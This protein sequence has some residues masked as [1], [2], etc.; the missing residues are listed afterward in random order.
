[1]QSDY[2]F[3]ISLFG[4]GGVGKTSLAH[5]YLHGAFDIDTKMTMGASI[6]V[7]YV[8]VGDKRV[9]LQIWDFGGEENFRFLLPVYAQ[10]SSAGILMYDISRYDTFKGIEEWLTFFKEGLS[11]DE[12]NIPLFLV[13]GK[14]DLE[15][16]RSVSKED[17]KKKAE[18]LKVNYFVET[19][20]KTGKNI[21]ELFKAVT[22]ALLKKSGLL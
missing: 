13:G 8:N 18:E 15:E 6:L 7:K 17:A 3:K 22:K 14:L 16:K 4:A 11:I 5:R 2:T 10:G 20:A 19:S 21:E 1:M 12:Q 9:A